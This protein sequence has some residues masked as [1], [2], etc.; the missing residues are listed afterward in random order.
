MKKTFIEALSNF[1]GENCEKKQEQLVK[2]W[3]QPI[4]DQEYFAIY[5]S[6]CRQ[7]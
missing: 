1:Y 3:T 5:N 6:C 2:Q 7:K 4:G